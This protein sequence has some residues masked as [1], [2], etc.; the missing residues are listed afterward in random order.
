MS[1]SD[2]PGYEGYGVFGWTGATGARESH[3][4]QGQPNYTPKPRQPYE[5]LA[6]WSLVMAF[7]GIS[8]L[9]VIFG[10]MSKHRSRKAGM[11]YS[12]MASAGLMIGY[13]YLSFWVL[14][15]IVAMSAHTGSH[16]P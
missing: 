3:L 15:I 6:I 13:I 14:L 4:R 9:A 7:I 2:Y 8:P 16:Q 10:H 11:P 5:R 1:L 12:G